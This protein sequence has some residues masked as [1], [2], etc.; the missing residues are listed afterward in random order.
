MGRHFFE[1]DNKKNE[2]LNEL[3]LFFIKQDPKLKV[4]VDQIETYVKEKFEYTL[5]E[6]EKVYLMIHINKLVH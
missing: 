5:E 1:K 4:C 3:Y 2:D 6:Y